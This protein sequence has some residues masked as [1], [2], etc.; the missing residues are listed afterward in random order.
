M[1]ARRHLPTFSKP[2]PTN[3]SPV[4]TPATL[5]EWWRDGGVNGRARALGDVLSKA[6]LNLDVMDRLDVV[7]RTSEMARVFGID[8]YSVW[9]RA[10]RQ[11]GICA[12]WLATCL[13]VAMYAL[14]TRV[15]VHLN[16]RVT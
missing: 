1:F 3:R 4:Y 9:R 2:T 10:C 15:F 16:S 12:F 5:W 13:C 11:G 8:F 7:G 14:L 6:R